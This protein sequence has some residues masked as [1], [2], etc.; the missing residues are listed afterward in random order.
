[1]DAK[2]S[3]DGPNFKGLLILLVIILAVG[4]TFAALWNNGK[5]QADEDQAFTYACELASETPVEA[6][7]CVESMKAQY[8]GPLDDPDRIAN[9]VAE[10]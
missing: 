5:R 3:N 8:E 1:M 9:A 2:T 6:Q 7:A 4:G 10:H